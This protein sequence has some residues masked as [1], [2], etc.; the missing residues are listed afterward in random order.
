MRDF[1][2]VELT[3]REYSGL[4]SEQIRLFFYDIEIALVFDDF[5]HGFAHL[6]QCS[7]HLGKRC[8]CHETNRCPTSQGLIP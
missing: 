1:P 6:G 2:I 3:K 8:D 7:I 4:S 5:S